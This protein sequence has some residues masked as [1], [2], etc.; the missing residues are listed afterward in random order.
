VAHSLFWKVEENGE[1]S[2]PWW[3]EELSL[4]AVSMTP[5][6]EGCCE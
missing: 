1:E 3:L 4:W 2:D 6:R 5:E